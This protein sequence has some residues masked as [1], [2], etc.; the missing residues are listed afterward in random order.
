MTATVRTEDGDEHVF[1]LSSDGQKTRAMD[2]I[3]AAVFSDDG[4]KVYVAAGL[5]L[6]CLDLD[7]GVQAW[8]YRP[9][10]LYGF[11]QSTPR[12]IGIT[13][14]KNVFLC[15]D[16][17]TM[18]L[19]RPD[20]AHVARWRSSLSPNMVSRHYNGSWFYGSDG[21]GVTVWD[22][23]DRRLIMS[24]RSSVRVYAL[25]GFPK[26]DRVVV[27]TDAG[28]SIIDAFN[29]QVQRTFPVGYGLPILD[30]SPDGNR[31]LVGQIRGIGIYDLEGHRTG[32]AE[33]PGARVLSARFHP[34]GGLVLGTDSGSIVQVPG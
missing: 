20:G 22:P 2:R 27:R 13:A 24:I 31:I 23:E 25:R 8:S 15:N 6:R 16:N 1:K 18:D 11:L 30:V 4:S 10:N 19:F 17:G 5:H 28:V 26:S 29:G 14:N 32:G 12:A 7:R 33:V 9:A 34:Q 3:H 21:H